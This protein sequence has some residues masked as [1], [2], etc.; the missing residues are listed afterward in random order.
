MI[1]GGEI[2]W[3]GLVGAA[4]G[5]GLLMMVCLWGVEAVSKRKSRLFEALVSAWVMLSCALAAASGLAVVLLGVLH[6]LS[7]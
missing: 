3:Y 7:P 6:V 4:S 1:Y 5:S 2:G